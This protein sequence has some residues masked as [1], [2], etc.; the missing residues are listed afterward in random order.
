MLIFVTARLQRLESEGHSQ[1]SPHVCKEK[2]CNL[3]A[4]LQFLLLL[5]IHA[6]RQGIVNRVWKR[7]AGISLPAGVMIDLSRSKRELLMENALL[8]QQ[9]KV[10][11]R[12]VTRPQL[13]KADRAL[14]V[15]L[16]GRLRSWKSALFIVQ[17]DTVLRWHR[18]AFRLFWKCKS[19]TTSRRPKL[20][21]E[22]IQLI[23]QM[24][25]ENRLWGAERVR[26]ELL[27]LNIRV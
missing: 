9:L 8:R 16:A 2:R 13:T 12:Q 18:Q 27:K 21:D 7:P 10:L 23:K 5:V 4:F 25:A 3:A 11:R 6:L 17:P 20:P 26:G 24:A 19:R 22:T 1:L 15:L 14:L